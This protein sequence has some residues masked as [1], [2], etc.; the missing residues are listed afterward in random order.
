MAHSHKNTARGSKAL[1]FSPLTEQRNDAPTFRQSVKHAERCAIQC[2]PKTQQRTGNCTNPKNQF[3]SRIDH[4]VNGAEVA[5]AEGI[6]TDCCGRPLPSSS[7]RRRPGS[8]ADER[9]PR[10]GSPPTELSGYGRGRRILRGFRS[11]LRFGNPD[12]G[13]IGKETVR[14]RARRSEICVGVRVFG[15]QIYL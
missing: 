8:P 4:R 3:F 9:D 11:A 10:E 6:A 1:T 14:A 12:G 7:L 13:A 5:R 15:K 2:P